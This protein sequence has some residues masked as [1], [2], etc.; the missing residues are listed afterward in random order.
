MNGPARKGGAN[1]AGLLVSQ[2]HV[3]GMNGTTTVAPRAHPRGATADH[4]GDKANTGADDSI[5]KLDGSP[6]C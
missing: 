4:A 1:V 2:Y 6:V 3:G 5:E